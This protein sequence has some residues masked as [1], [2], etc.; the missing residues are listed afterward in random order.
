MRLFYITR[1]YA[2]YDEGGGALMRRWTVD[3]LTDMGWDVQVVRPEY[4]Q[5]RYYKKENV[6]NIPF[7]QRY[8]QKLL[9]LLERIGWHEDYLDPWVKSSFPYLLKIIK[10]EDMIFCTSGGELG[11]IKLGS[12]LKEKIGCKLI[13]NFRD[14]LNY[15]YMQGIRRDMKPHVGRIGAQRKYLSNADLIVTS[16]KRYCKI[17]QSGFPELGDKIHSNYF[18]FGKFPK[19]NNVKK[20]KI[21]KLLKMPQMSKLKKMQKGSNL[22][23]GK[24][25]EKPSKCQNG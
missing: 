13:V 5:R 2:P 20:H 10:K 8:R 7:A 3:Y 4:K 1:S 11:T 22:K 16:S 14:P 9:S 21:S 12:I 17:L 25:M 19:E 15:G 6:L 23:N 24:K 18:G